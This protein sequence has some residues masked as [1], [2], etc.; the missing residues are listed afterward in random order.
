VVA[1]EGKDI[2]EGRD[3]KRLSNAAYIDAP[4]LMLA[5]AT[6]PSSLA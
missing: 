6:H 2:E 4:I 5:S 1:R 3:W